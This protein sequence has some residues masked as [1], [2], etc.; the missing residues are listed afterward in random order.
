MTTDGIRLGEREYRPDMLCENTK[1]QGMGNRIKNIVSCLRITGN[2]EVHWSRDERG[3]IWTTKEVDYYFP[4]LIPVDNKTN[5]YWRRSWR[6]ALHPGEVEPNFSNIGDMWR[7]RM[8]SELGPV[9]PNKDTI[10]LEYNRVPESVKKSYREVFASLRINDEILDYVEQNSKEFTDDV[11]SVHV[12]TW[13]DAGNRSRM[14]S[15]QKYI[16]ILDRHPEGKI[17][18]TGD[19]KKA[20]RDISSKYGNRV[21]T[22]TIESGKEHLSAI[23]DIL[24]LSKGRRF[25]VSPF[26]SFGECAWWFSGAIAK[27]DTAW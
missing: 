12:R 17:F 5:R 26:S 16:D 6:L 22:H 4:D 25:V 18:I 1:R 23:A 9:L 21:I 8:G 14:Y 2:R 13:K 24:L 3:M 15:P 10:D 19:S 11:I 20:I 7:Q 27:V